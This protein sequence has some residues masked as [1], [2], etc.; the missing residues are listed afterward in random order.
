M[1]NIIGIG[2]LVL[3]VYHNHIVGDY[4]YYVGG[5][6]WNDLINLSQ[7][8]SETRCYCVATCGKDWAGDFLVCE[9]N[10]VGID[11][12]NVLRVN[13]QTKRFNIVVDRDN[14]ISQLECPICKQIVWYSD[15]KLPSIPP[16]SLTELDPGIIII[17]SLKKNTIEIAKHFKESGW[18]IAADLGHI[19]HMRYMSKENLRSVI[20][21]VFG[22]VQMTN[23]VSKFL[24]GKL[25]CKNEQDLFGILNCKYLNITDGDNGSKFVYEN[26]EKGIEIIPQSAK[27]IDVVDPTGA[28]DAYFSM[29]LHQLSN[30]MSF[31]T[32]IENALHNSRDYA[33][34]RV[35]V[36]GAHGVYKKIE[37]SIEGCAICGG[38]SKEKNKTVVKRQKIATNTNYLLDRTLRA[39]ESDAAQRL[40]DLLLSSKGNM[41]MVGTGGSYAAAV[42]AAK[43]ITEFHPTSSAQACHPRDLFVQGLNKIDLVLLFSYSGKT[44]DIQNVYNLC[45]KEGVAVF[46]L[47]KYEY[48]GD[49]NLYEKETVISYSASKSSTKERGFISMAGTLIPMSLFGEVFF[50]NTSCSFREYLKDCFSRRSQE[51]TKDKDYF[52]LPERK[53]VVDIFSG[54]DTCCA[55]LDLESKFVESG[56]ARVTIHEKK[57]FSHGRFN[58]VEKHEPN[59]IIFLDN[60]FG[61]YSEKLL[62]YLEKR[63]H[64]YICHLVSNQGLIWGD[65]DLVIASEFF[66]KYLSRVLGYDMATPDYP[67][68]AMSLYKYS[69]KNLL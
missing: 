30:D 7:L 9:L 59:L 37:R 19:S 57:D 1:K 67:A 60:E 20:C 16:N 69:R 46:V 5:S 13:K 39:L 3:D 41:M 35:S 31:S 23:R 12:E 63:D 34:N 25:N 66:S 56:L 54:L 52:C 14:S 64:L 2:D 28:G 62:Q 53:L 36:V 29:L 32:E 40:H 17:D 43:C 33:A 58:I 42:F 49:D 65:L 51:F 68:D 45:K 27:K 21:G 22:I 26:P 10:K 8:D 38:V 24:L 18:V 4:G 15:A 44:K 50:P 61:P 55:A 48:S 11:T 6:V 47:T